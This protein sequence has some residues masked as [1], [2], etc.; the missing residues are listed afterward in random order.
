[1]RVREVYMKKDSLVNAFKVLLLFLI[2]FLFELRGVNAGGPMGIRYAYAPN[3]N[4]KFLGLP[5][6]VW[7]FWGIL[8][9]I[10]IIT[11]NAIF[12]NIFKLGLGFF[13]KSHFFLYPLFDAIFVTS[14]D[15]FIDP[16]SVK[17]GLWKWFNFN[18]GYF[19]VPIG[20]FIGWFV[21]VF[22]TSLL[23]RFI[24]MKSDRIIT[25]LVIPKMPLYTILIIL[26]FI[27]T[28]L[29]INIDCALM[30]LLY[31]LP[32]IVLDIYSKYFMFSSLNM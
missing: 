24:D 5:L 3:F 18:D 6:L 20:N 16:F 25:H 19:G 30:G 21:I 31:A 13:S 1:M 12:Q 11:T 26:L 27:K 22:T 8:I 23:V 17:L 10:G 2:P 9:F 7:L 29:V 15:I 32:L 14:F 28:M 4:P